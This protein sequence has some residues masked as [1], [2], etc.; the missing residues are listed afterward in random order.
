M[1][2]RCYNE[3]HQRYNLYEAKG[4]T[5]CEGWKDFKT[6]KS[7][8]IKVEGYDE[9]SIL[10][11]LLHLDKDSKDIENKIYSPET[12]CFISKE[13]NNKYKPNQMRKFIGTNPEGIEYEGSNQSDFAKEYNLKQGSISDCLRGKL[14]T[15]KGWK[16]N[17]K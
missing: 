13:I 7:T 4:V 3:R 1:N 11:G 6:F 17:F 8:V 5:V 9:Q 2:D 12:C 10:D 16:F 14:K 15:H